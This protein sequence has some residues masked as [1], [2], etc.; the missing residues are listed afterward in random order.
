MIIR[1]YQDKDLFVIKEITALCFDGVCID[2]NI[3]NLVGEIDSKSWQWRKVRHIDADVATNASGVFVAEV[4]KRVVGYITTRIDPES[5]VGGIPNIA[6]LPAAQGEGIGR[7]LME[8]AILYFQE[9][10]MHYTRIE[11]LDQNDIGSD[12]YPN[13][14]F[15]EV[16]RQIHYVMSIPDP[17]GDGKG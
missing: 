11:T 9:V 12:F 5:K 16:A 1:S 3:E 14:G 13:M 6:V 17:D 4:D 7:A 2:Q 15:K 10:G 8:R